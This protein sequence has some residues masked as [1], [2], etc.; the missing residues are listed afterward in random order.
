MIIFIR[1][2][3]S[4][5]DKLWVNH[6]PQKEGILLKLTLLW[7]NSSIIA[8]SA[9]GVTILY[10]TFISNIFDIGTL[11]APTLAAIGILFAVLNSVYRIATYGHIHRK[12]ESDIDEDA[13]KKKKRAFQRSYFSFIL[14][15]L[16][17][18]YLGIGITILSDTLIP[19]SI[20]EVAS[21]G[22][23]FDY[24]LIVV[25]ST[26]L[27]SITSE[28]LLWIGPLQIPNV[29]IDNLD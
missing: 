26:L 10:S 6:V 4:F 11:S 22:T 7:R 16:I 9:V 25:A 1:G 28:I 21:I 14:S 19:E 23:A 17:F 27:L 5:I 15:L 29:L 18:A 20:V 2:L 3:Y 13:I 12:D 24:T 8:L